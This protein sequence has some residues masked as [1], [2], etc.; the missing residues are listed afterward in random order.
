MAAS[1]EGA[2][3]GGLTLTALHSTSCPAD[4]TRMGHSP[5]ARLRRR[6]AADSGFSLIEAI[7]ALSILALVS[8]SFSYGMNLAL[9]VTRDDR[10][11]QQA[12]HL[13][14]REL[15]IVRN[16]FQHSDES[17][18][19]GV[20]QAGRV[21]NDAPLP[22]GTK[23]QPLEIDGREF[24]VERTNSIQLKGN[25][26]SPCDGGG[27][28]D[29]LTIA[30]NVAVSWSDSSQ[31]R[32]VESNTLLTPVKGVEGDV[33]YIAAKLTDSAG[34][35][36]EN[37]AVLA[38]G[39]STSATQYTAAD[40]CA[41]FMFST[42]G[43]YTLELNSAGYVN[44]EGFQST[45]KTATLEKGKLKVIPFSYDRAAGLSVDFTTAPGHALPSPLPG[46]TLLHSGLQPSGMR[47]QQGSADPATV[48]DLW[49]VSDGY[50]IW[51][52]TCD[53]SDPDRNGLTHP[54]PAA[55][56]VVAGAVTDVTVAMAPVAVRTV[57]ALVPGQGVDGVTLVAKPVDSTGCDASELT[58]TLGTTSGGG[59]L[60]ASL[61][62]GSWLVEPQG[63]GVTCVPV[64]GVS[65]CPEDTGTLVVVDQ[66]GNTPDPPT[67]VTLP[68]M[69]VTLP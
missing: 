17:G 43:D 49:P 20:L 41:V 64:D 19:L 53:Q 62:A 57:A 12:T 24:V 60:N 50:T 14:E 34:G 68:D 23:G 32:T 69:E 67:V 11:R 37:V 63:A 56:P 46:V 7:V 33:G 42:A 22:G 59:Y 52:G 16:K 48:T 54:R 47:R 30:V 25:G 28:V 1:Q 58:L 65:A 61:P 35:G 31:T 8:T 5:F 55:V 51:A 21:I 44:Q 2:V 10:L 27:L 40:G 9:R 18:Q 26:E 4:N 45:G 6:L 13:A 15:E 66:Q 3:S 39:P 36:T 38:S 29:Y